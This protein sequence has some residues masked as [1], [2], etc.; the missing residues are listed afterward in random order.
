MRG[1]KTSTV[2]ILGNVNGGK[3]EDA[4]H[5]L[6]YL[7]LVRENLFT[8]LDAVRHTTFRA[9]FVDQGQADVDALEFILN[10]RDFDEHTPIFVLKSAIRPT[11]K[12]LVT[13]QHNVLLLD[14]VRELLELESGKGE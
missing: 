9:I 6:G 8:A 1:R 10:V 2:L 7:P 11:E 3:L 13:K 14:G 5:D 4:L 12:E